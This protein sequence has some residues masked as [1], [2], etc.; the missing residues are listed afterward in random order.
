ML[1]G[2]IK[3]VSNNNIEPIEGDKDD[4]FIACVSFEDRTTAIADRFSKKYKIANSFVFKYDEKNMT[5][6]RDVNF[7]KLKSKIEQHSEKIFP[8]ICNHH[9]PL[10]GVFK[11]RDLLKNNMPVLENK[12]ITIDITTF[13]KQYILVLLRF[14]ENQK[15]KSV[16]VFYAE[17]EDYAV[18][19]GKPLS[20]GLIDVVSVPSYGGHYYTEKEN[21][22]IL[23]LGYEGDRAYGLW[24]KCAPHKTIVLIGKPSFKESWEGRVEEFNEKLLSKLPENSK[25]YI[26]TLN[27]FEVSRNLDGLIKKYLGKFNISISPLGPKPQVLGCYLSMRKHREVQIIYAIPKSHEEEYFSKRVGKVWEYR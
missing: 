18:K 4:I 23:Q 16:R 20:S 22:L 17:P 3:K 15:P 12:N 10:D 21:L 1:K 5:N 25:Q 24:E 13:T 8:I 27:P 2:I 19:W 11:F 26:P 7:E 9:D 14:I 6:L